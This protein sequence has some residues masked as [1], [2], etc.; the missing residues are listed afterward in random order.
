MA[1]MALL[2]SAITQPSSLAMR[3]LM[4]K[5][6]DGGNG[7]SARKVVGGHRFMHLDISQIGVLDDMVDALHDR[8]EVGLCRD[9]I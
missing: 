4:T 9:R 2:L 7:D 1:S 8:Q 5:R 6:T 3:L